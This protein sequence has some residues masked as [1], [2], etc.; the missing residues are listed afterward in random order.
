MTRLKRLA[1]LVC[2]AGAMLLAPALVAPGV[3]SAHA[4]SRTLKLYNVHTKERVQITFKKDGRYIPGGLRDANRFLRDWRRN[5][6]TNIDPNLLDLVWE[7]YQ[8]VG[9]RDYIHVVSSYRSPATN[10]MLRGRSRGVAQ[11]SQHMLG[12]AMDFFIPGVDLAKLR[13]TGLRRQVGGVGFYP[14]SGSPFVHMDTGSVRHWPKM[15]RQQLANVFPDGKTVHIPSDGKPMQGYQ[16]ALAELKSGR[17]SAP[18]VVASN[19]DDEEGGSGNSRMNTRGQ[20]LTSGDDGRIVRPASTGGRNF[21]A[22]LFSGEDDDVEEAAA[23]PERAPAQV[24]P[25]AVAARGTAAATP[26]AAAP[27]QAPAAAPARAPEPEAPVVTAATLPQGKPAEAREP[28]NI[29]FQIASADAGGVS[30]DDALKQA[31]AAPVPASAPAQPAA[32]VQQLAAVAVPHAKPQSAAARAVAQA[33]D[34]VSAILAATGTQ[35]APKPQLAA[36]A[37]AYAS[38]AATQPQPATQDVLR[39]KAAEAAARMARD[40]KKPAAPAPTLAGLVPSQIKDPLAGFARA[41]DK[42]SPEIISAESTLRTGTFAKM[43]HPNQRKLT[44]LL[45]PGNRFLKNSFT[46]AAPQDIRADS[47]TGNAVAILPVVYTR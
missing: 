37:M 9:G 1:A 44:E 14:T 41:P 3:S 10:N 8:Q 5:E 21:L 32:A 36:A 12:K 35:P 25:G 40:K 24:R 7:V 47:F 18:V 42:T 27:V 17:R 38:Q 16:Q 26:P 22:A 11:K 43:S 15:T 34:P 6:I 2:V 39:A 20:T 19:S 23:Q 45:E 28:A 33:T 46:T 29:P 31:A 4:E 13:A 30:A